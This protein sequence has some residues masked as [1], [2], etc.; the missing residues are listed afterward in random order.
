MG[1]HYELISD[2]QRYWAK[3]FLSLEMLWSRRTWPASWR[4]RHGPDKKCACLGTFRARARLRL[5]SL[6]KALPQLD[7]HFSVLQIQAVHPQADRKSRSSDPLRFWYVS[8]ALSHSRW[9][10]LVLGSCPSWG[11]KELWPQLCDTVPD[12]VPLGTP[13]SSSV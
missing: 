9:R 2:G 6:C 12:T 13:V 10:Y 8:R 11:G 3:D 5:S 7:H 1:E 4:E